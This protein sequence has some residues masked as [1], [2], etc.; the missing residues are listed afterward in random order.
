MATTELPIAIQLLGSTGAALLDYLFKAK[1][2]EAIGTGD[3]LLRF[4]ALYYAAI[5]LVTFI[6]Q[7]VSSRVALERFGLA[8]TAGTPSIAVLA[9]SIGGLG[10]TR[11]QQPDGSTGGRIDLPCVVVSRRVRAFLH[12]DS[13]CRETRCQIYR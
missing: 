8:L 4:F 10:D 6:L 1:A 3:E 12:A 13:S 2:V 9:G 11:R 5:S 7:V